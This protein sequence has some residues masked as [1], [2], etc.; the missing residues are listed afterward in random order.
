MTDPVIAEHHR[1]CFFVD[2]LDEFEN[3]ELKHTEVAE[4][5][6]QWVSH[7]PAGIKFCV[8]SREEPAFMNSFTAKQRL[9]LHLLTRPDI[10]G[11]G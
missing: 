4:Y 3:Q 11:D 5:I 7:N 10:G 8:S 1:F 9:R 6:R 2:G